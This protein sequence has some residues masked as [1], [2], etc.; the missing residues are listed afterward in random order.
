VRRH[1]N[2]IQFRCLIVIGEF[3][4]CNCEAA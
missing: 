1:W 4:L 3:L 2:V